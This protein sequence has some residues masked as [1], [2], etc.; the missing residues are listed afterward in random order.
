[1]A[2]A[3]NRF[4]PFLAV[5]AVVIVGVIFYMNRS[6]GPASAPMQSVPLPKT[7]GADED[8]PAETL[9]TVVASNRELRQDVQRVLRENEDL[10][11]QLKLGGPAPG[12]GAPGA[13]PAP[14]AAGEPPAA[15]RGGKAGGSSTPIDV[16]NNAWGN[17]VGTLGALGGNPQARDPADVAGGTDPAADGAAGAVGYKVVP[18]MGYVAQTST[19]QGMVTTRYVRSP[20]SA[21]AAAG[22]AAMGPSNGSATRAAQA[23]AATKPEPV[24][25][26]TIPENS[27]LAGVTAM[28]SLI[29]RVPVN[30][31]VTDPMQ[32]KAMV[33]RDNL[34]ANG[35][36]LP[37]DL[38]GMVIT[39]VAIGDMALS[40]T[41]GKVRSMTFVFNDG[42][43]RTVSSRRSSSS[44][45]GG[46]TSGSNADLGFISDLHGNPC[47][48]GKF[49]TNAPSYLTDIVGAKGLGVAAEALAQA[50]TTTLN[51][52]DSTSAAV[53]GSAGSFAL[54]RMGSGAADELTKWL[55]ERLKSSFDAV[56]T[57]AGQQLVVHLDTEVQIDKPANLRKIVHRTQSTNVQSG[58]RHGLD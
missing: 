36:E 21:A 51:R 7:T 24:A 50:Q 23:A 6:A 58:A 19:G 2:V 25:F 1:M 44:S 27:T 15:A 56:V 9:A 3:S 49:V 54:G 12:S 26:F 32:F 52:G 13:E 39:G 29:G 31:R 10:R 18:P 48:Q 46:L 14:P 55:T 42:S 45:N 30:G 40:C 43:I 20:G 17:A 53:T 4:V 22:I 16:L 5:V 8:T 57:P 41:E 38:A 35:W 28:T 33:G 37:D 47:I 11:K 34:A